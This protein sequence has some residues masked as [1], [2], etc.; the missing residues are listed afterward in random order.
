MMRERTIGPLLAAGVVGLAVFAAAMFGVLTRPFG[1]LAESWPANALL[2]GLFIAFPTLARPGSW[3]AAVAAYLLAD[4][5]AG[6]TL[7]VNVWLTA[8]NMAGVATG[9]VLYRAM[10]AE[11][12]RMDQASA[13]LYLFVVCACA[14]GAAALVGSGLSTMMF[15]RPAWAG[16]AVWF[17]TECNRYVILLT[18]CLAGQRW[19]GERRRLSWTPGWRHVRH[20]GP[21]LTLALSVGLMVLLGGPGAIAFPVPALL[22]CALAYPIFPMS[23]VVVAFNTAITTLQVEGLIVIPHVYSHTLVTT[24]F[25]LGLTLM[26]LG[27]LTVSTIMER[28]RQLI[29]QL[30]RAVAWDSLTSAL[31]RRTYLELS[32]EALLRPISASFKG[33]AVMMLDL[34]LFKQINDGMGHF[35]GDVVLVE[36]TRAIAGE[37]RH[38]DLFGRMGGE[39]FAITL[40]DIAP[41]DARSLAERLRH[42]VE[43]LE[44]T[45]DGGAAIF[46][47]I[48]IGMVH[49]SGHGLTGLRPLLAA[50][51]AALYL[52][53][54]GGRNKVV[55]FD[56][57][58]NSEADVCA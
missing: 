37:L 50:A 16:F 29:A 5:L 8:A 24:S 55:M 42:R 9:Y 44:I 49:A 43:T 45:T 18:V 28:Q 25:R 22:W 38:T 19:L 4:G 30:H 57:E 20:V 12:R 32:E 53:K 15:N 14:A 6:D 13:M 58:S 39:E 36:V 26:V 27:P 54:A 10:G 40:F 31:A 1:L 11:R 52:A 48:S 33:V 21:L 35:A 23:L 3:L 56:A 51:D 47:T 7:L 34:D 17:S 41:Q 2:L 46:V